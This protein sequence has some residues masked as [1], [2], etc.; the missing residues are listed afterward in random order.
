MDCDI[1]GLAETFFT[2]KQ[3]LKVKGY[4]WFGQ[5]RKWI[6]KTAK[7]GSGGI[8]FLVHERM[9]EKF[10]VEV[11]DDEYEGILWL[12]FVGKNVCTVFTACVAYLVPQHSC[13]AV[14]GNDFYDTL[15]GKMYT[16]QNIGPMYIC[17]DLNSR[18]GALTDFIEGVDDMSE[19][20]VVDYDVNAYGDM[21][22]EFLIS[23]NMC[24][25]NG[26]N[27]ICNDFTRIGT[28][29]RSVVDYCVVSHEHLSKFTQFEVHRMI[30]LMEI[31]GIM[32]EKPPDHSILCWD[33][34]VGEMEDVNICENVNKY[35]EVCKYDVS[36]VPDDFMGDESV[37]KK[38]QDTISRLE[39]IEGNQHVVNEMYDTFCNI[40]T[41]EMSKT[42]PCKVL[43]VYTGNLKRTKKRKKKNQP[44]WCPSVEN[45]WLQMC[46]AETEWLSCSD[47]PRRRE[48]KAD[49]VRACKAFDKERQKCKRQFWKKE[50]D[51]LLDE[52]ETD[53]NKFWKSI[54]KIGISNDRKPGIPMEVYD[55]EGNLTRNV[56]AVMRKW[57]D[58]FSSLFTLSNESGFNEEFLKNVKQRVC[59]CEQIMEYL[60]EEHSNSGV[61]YGNLNSDITADEVKKAV[62]Q[63]KKGKAMGIDNIPS[64]VLQSDV[65]QLFMIKLFNNCFKHGVIPRCWQKGVINPIPKSGDPRVPLNYR[66]ITLTCHMYKMYCTV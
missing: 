63:S 59:E 64:E 10:S 16:Y 39:Q 56:E 60:Y 8:G 20:D 57:K 65:V 25:L 47:G 22:I 51:R 44:W 55:S 52:C 9:L 15:L 18:V 2:G 41:T 23:S 45:L 7:R 27:T 24:I 50:Q 19:R 21:L 61:E 11:I 12:K 62:T 14:D 32:V 1:L 42:L 34:D 17:G 37:V 40:V 31:T 29:G 35:K 28:T 3:K 4:E 48:K 54:G 33:F 5:N 13:R 66:G 43:K 6:K 53:P 46:Q 26:R 30:K 36:N 49:Y 38:I 58:E